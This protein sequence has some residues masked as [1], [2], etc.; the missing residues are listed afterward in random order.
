MKHYEEGGAKISAMVIRNLGFNILKE[1]ELCILRNWLTDREIEGVRL[2]SGATMLKEIIVA[3]VKKDR[4]NKKLLGVMNEEI[5]LR[6]QSVKNVSKECAR[7]TDKKKCSKRRSADGAG[8]SGLRRKRKKE[9][10][11]MKAMNSLEQ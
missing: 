6:E 3:N 5:R 2:E 9:H 10:V 11:E 4:A 1:V 7:E 8:P